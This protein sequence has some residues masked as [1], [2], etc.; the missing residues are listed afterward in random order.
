MLTYVLAA[1][2]SP[3]MPTYNIKKVRRMLQ[4]GR[5]V[6]ADHKPGFTIRLTSYL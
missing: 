6:L 5:A 2:G 4:N 3:L 1:D